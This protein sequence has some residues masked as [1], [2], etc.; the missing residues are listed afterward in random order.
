DGGKTWANVTPKDM[1]E[2]GRVSQI[3]A[4]AFDV[5]TAYVSVRRPLLDDKSPYIWKTNDFGRTWTKI[6]NGIR[7]D[8]WIHAVREDPTRR[9][10]LYAA[11]QHGV[12]LSYDDGATWQSLSLNLADG[13]VSDLVV[14]A[15]DLVIGTHGRGFYVLDNI[16]P[17]REFT[18]AVAGANS[19]LYVPRVMFRSASL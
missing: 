5:G 2:Y 7:A 1:P 12:Y 16:W 13:P 3:D 11:A 15:N 10:L 9:G 14:E 17:L 8:D 4:S 19:V 18:P 6:V